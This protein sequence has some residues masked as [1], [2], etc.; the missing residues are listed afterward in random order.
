MNL[1]WYIFYGR[2]LNMNRQEVVNTRFGEMRDM[3]SCLS[4][5]RGEC[6]PKKKKK[7]LTYDEVMRMR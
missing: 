6:V 2:Q 3:I 5:Y 7:K 1:S 4:I